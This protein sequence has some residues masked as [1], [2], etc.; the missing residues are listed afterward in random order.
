MP[1]TKFSGLP[2]LSPYDV[3]DSNARFVVVTDTPEGRLVNA[4]DMGQVVGMIQ[5]LQGRGRT[6][7]EG[8]DGSRFD[9]QV[10]GSSVTTTVP[11]W[12]GDDSFYGGEI[13]VR[14]GDTNATNAPGGGDYLY[15][16]GSDA[17][18][19]GGT[20]TINGTHESALAYGG[21]ASVIGG[22]GIVATFNGTDAYATGGGSAL[23]IG[24][25]ASALDG[26]GSVNWG[27]TV[28]A[29]GGSPGGAGGVNL[30]GGQ[31]ILTG[32]AGGQI[33]IVGGTGTNGD[34]GPVNIDGGTSLGFDAGD[35][36]VR[37][38][39]SQNGDGGTVI[40][41]GGGTVSGDGGHVQLRAG[42]SIGTDG[43]VFLS[44]ADGLPLV[45]VNSTGLGFYSTAPI[46]KPTGVPVDAAGIHAAL[47]ALGLIGA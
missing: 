14:A 41:E 28:V 26:D 38:G 2:L 43:S 9:V 30:I 40:I 12:D 11:E 45:E 13:R 7:T 17:E 32:T 33:T 34:G 47:V 22:D 27:G 37:G 18:V 15:L 46:A 19:R 39:L 3:E 44:R 6:W 23:L 29:V 8:V 25:R 10:N 1:D 42:N 5:G 16:Y 31:G 36:T 4:S 24:G 35:V 21:T 20:V